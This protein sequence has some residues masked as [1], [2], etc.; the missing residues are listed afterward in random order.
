MW[1]RL[2]MRKE[3]LH[4]FHPDTV[5]LRNRFV[6]WNLESREACESLSFS[7]SPFLL[8][9]ELASE[10]KLRLVF[11]SGV[12]VRRP[13]LLLL[14]LLFLSHKQSRRCIKYQLL[15]RGASG[16]GCGCAAFLFR[17]A[18]T[19]SL[20]FLISLS[21]ALGQPAVRCRQQ[22]VI[23]ASPCRIERKIGAVSQR[24]A[25]PLCISACPAKLQTRELSHG[26]CACNCILRRGKKED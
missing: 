21:F 17:P 22:P 26:M 20:S 23:M 19:K 8:P 14:F 4:F 16:L 25:R 11:V 7:L 24:L 2:R 10:A 6:N 9:L 12:R 13:P 5:R 1:L 15:C 3:I 18:E